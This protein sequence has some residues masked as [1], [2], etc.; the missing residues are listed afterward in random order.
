MKKQILFLIGLIVTNILLAQVPQG[1]SHQAVIRDANNELV[2][3]STIGIQVSI[4]QG[5][6]EGAAVYIETHT[7]VSNANGLITY[8]I[9]DGAVESGVFAEIDWSAG[10]YFLKT[11][12]DP[13]GGTNYT[14]TGVTELMSVPYALHAKTVDSMSFDFE[15]EDPVF[16]ESPASGIISE[17]IDNWDAAFN[18]GDHGE[19]GY[20]TEEVQT[21][22]DVAALD[23]SVNT[24]IKDLTDPTDP[25]DAATKAYV[26]LL[27]SI[28]DSL[29]VRIEALEDGLFAPLTDIDGNEYE[30]VIIGNQEWMA[31]NLRVTRYNNGDDILTDS[32]G[33]YWSE[34]TEGAYAIYPHTGGLTENDVEGIESD[35]EMV[36][37]YGKLYNWYAVD[38][39]RG[40]CPEGWSVPSHDDWTQ[41]EQYICNTLGNSDCENHFP[42]SNTLI[43]QRGTNEG[44]ALKSCRQVGSPLEGCNTSEHPRW[45][46]H[47]IHYG[48]DEVGFSAH[49][50]GRRDAFGLHLNIMTSAHYWS[51]SESS[52]LFYW[53]RSVHSYYGTISRISE[54]KRAGLSVRCIRD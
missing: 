4:L 34:T 44:N 20:L 18:W 24:Q 1:I 25:Q 37:A 9:G 35:A 12:A 10:P 48:F 19:E 43:G 22:A 51:S 5:G 2:A 17:D 39:A 46:S 32:S 42:Y 28:V 52:S 3:N 6:A 21:L 49:P 26:D 14:I 7:P 47:S 45:D 30:T 41:L 27:A 23:N 36:A 31:E 8:I 16:M 50:G 40:L 53:R 11:E 15:E 54:A 29:L 13:T 38:D 33:D